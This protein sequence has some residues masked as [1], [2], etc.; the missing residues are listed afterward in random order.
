MIKK[1]NKDLSD[2]Y[3]YRKINNEEVAKIKEVSGMYFA[4]YKLKE[5]P[6]FLTPIFQRNKFHDIWFAILWIDSNLIEEYGKKNIE[7][8]FIF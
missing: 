2:Q 1:W 5:N 3:L 6:T 8:I 7:D 4:E